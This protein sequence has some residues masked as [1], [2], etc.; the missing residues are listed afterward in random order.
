MPRWWLQRPLTSQSA[1]SIDVVAERAERVEGVERAVRTVEQSQPLNIST[2]PLPLLSHPDSL[3][4]TC[5]RRI[6]HR[7]QQSEDP[8]HGISSRDLISGRWPADEDPRSDPETDD[9]RWV[10][11]LGGFL[12]ASSSEIILYPYPYPYSHFYIPAVPPEELSPTDSIPDH[13]HHPTTPF[14]RPRIISSPTVS[15]RAGSPRRSW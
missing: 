6:P 11:R 8:V 3:L 4:S 10:Y 12:L 13:S 7:H 2:L 9:G 5:P 14:I 15:S 1:S